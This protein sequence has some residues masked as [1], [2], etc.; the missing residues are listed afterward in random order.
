VKGE[1][2]L[3]GRLVER[4]LQRAIVRAALIAALEQARVRLDRG[5]ALL[6]APKTL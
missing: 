3:I 2:E 5:L 6:R 1:P 4:E